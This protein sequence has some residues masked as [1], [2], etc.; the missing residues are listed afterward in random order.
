MTMP[1]FAPS[2]RVALPDAMAGL[3][4]ILLLLL[5]LFSNGQAWFAAGFSLPLAGWQDFMAGKPMEQTALAMA[6]AGLPAGAAKI[7]RGLSWQL[8]GDL[9]PR[10]REGERDWLF[11]VDE[12]TPHPDGERDAAARAQEVIWL[13]Q[14]LARQG[15]ALL[16]AVIPDK[17]RVVAEHLGRLQR[18]AKFEYRVKEWAD[19]LAQAGI[20]VID[21]NDTLAG[22]Q[23]R[24]E[25]P[26]LR[27]DSHWTEAGAEA[28]A[29]RIASQI[30]RL[31]SAGQTS[32]GWRLT[33]QERRPRPGDL[34]RLAGIDWLPTALQPRTEWVQQSRFE[35]VASV[36]PT[37]RR[38]HAANA[39]NDDLFGDAELPAIAVIGSSFSR[40][41]NFVPFLA[42]HLQARVANFAVDGGDFAGAARAYLGSAAFKQTPPRLLLW[43][44]PERVLMADRRLDRLDRTD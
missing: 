26:F 36:T 5:G 42:Q 31:N 2:Q 3:C 39:D 38:I 7:E 12:L 34:V 23:A 20:E 4:F 17:S 28:A 33:G 6:K 35:P 13:N 14:R 1:P 8:A 25:I 37:L 11:L 43:E 15:I 22:L 29:A 16:V 9:G 19:R 21:L 18:S 24:R 27:T 30:Q 32:P 10:V 41:S 40:N 44:I